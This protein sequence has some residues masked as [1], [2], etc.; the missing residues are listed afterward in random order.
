MG[1]TI[2]QFHRLFSPLASPTTLGNNSNRT[3]SS[4]SSLQIEEKDHKEPQVSENQQQEQAAEE[5]EG[6]H[7]FEV[8]IN[9]DQYRLCKAKL[10]HDSSPGKSD[11][12]LTKRAL[13]ATEAHHLDNRALI[14]KLDEVFKLVDLDVST[15]L[16]EQIKDLVLGIVRSWIHKGNLAD[17]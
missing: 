14:A 1:K 16:S 9:T 11:T 5:D 8:N 3:Y 2:N 17:S 4:I 6:E 15:I 7:V 12:S 10:A 13:T